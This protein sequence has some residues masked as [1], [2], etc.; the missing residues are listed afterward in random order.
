MTFDRVL[1]S[2]CLLTRKNMRPKKRSD[3]ELLECALKHLIEEGPKAFTLRKIAAYV[4]V[5]P[6]TL[7]KRFGSRDKLFYKCMIHHM[8]IIKMPEV[9]KVK[10]LENFIS[11]QLGNIKRDNIIQNISLLAEDMSDHSLIKITREYF[12]SFRDILLTIIENDNR[13]QAID[14]KV[15]FTYQLE[16]I[17]NGAIIQGAFLKDISI[18]M[19]VQKRIA[20]YIYDKCNI[21]IDW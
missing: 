11:D 13:F 21:I 18:K 20:T 9:T 3:I 4:K 12:Q 1:W 10:A 6:A 8:S 16:S 14:N 19:N 15:E 2:K 17:F 7:I 5:S